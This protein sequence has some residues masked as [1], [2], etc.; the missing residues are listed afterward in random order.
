MPYMP[1][2]QLKSFTNSGREIAPRN[3]RDKVR[4]WREVQRITAEAQVMEIVKESD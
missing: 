1:G 2:E 4:R 3:G